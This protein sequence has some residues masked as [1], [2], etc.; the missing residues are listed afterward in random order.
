MSDNVTDFVTAVQ[1]AVELL[2]SAI[3]D[4]ADQIRIL[5]DLATFTGTADEPGDA[6]A[7]LCRRAALAS[8]ANATADWQPSSS[9]ETHQVVDVIAPIFDAEILYA[10]DKGDI[11]SYLQLRALRAAIITDLNRRGSQL[12]ELI[13][14]QRATSLPSLTLAWQLYADANRHTELLARNPQIAHPLFFPRNFEALSY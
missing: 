3:N 13:T 5:A 7:A 12:P 4:P 8:L 9:T 1:T 2:R 6:T 14:I 11:A 10:G